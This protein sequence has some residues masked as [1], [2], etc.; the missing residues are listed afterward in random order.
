MSKLFPDT[1]QF[2]I[3]MLAIATVLHIVQIIA[4]LL[5]EQAQTLGAG[6]MELLL[7]V[8]LVA[9]HAGTHIGTI[10]LAYLQANVTSCVDKRNKQLGIKSLLYL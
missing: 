9:L 4:G 10:R 2:T 5:A 7:A 1:N 6:H 8:C 3:M